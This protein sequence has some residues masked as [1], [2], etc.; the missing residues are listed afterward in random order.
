MGFQESHAQPEVNI[1]GLV[2]ASGLTELN[3]VLLGI[4][5][6]KEAESCPTLHCCFLTASQ[7]FCLV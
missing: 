4:V 1:L 3:D 2:G 7:C 6:E 5:S